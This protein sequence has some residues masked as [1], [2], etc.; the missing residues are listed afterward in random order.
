MKNFCPQ[1]DSNRDLPLTKRSIRSAYE[2]NSLSVALLVDISIEHLNVDR[3]L[4]ECAI[5]IYLYHVPRCGCSEMFC[6]VN[7]INFLQ[8]ANVLISQ[9]PK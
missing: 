5:K 1:R 8:S 7:F 9:I 2:A 3:V 6:H 4:P